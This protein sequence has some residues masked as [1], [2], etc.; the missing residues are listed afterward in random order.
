[1][2]ASIEQ[3]DEMKISTIFYPLFTIDLGNFDIASTE[4]L[5]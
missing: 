1:M 3:N 4:V 2:S 5:I